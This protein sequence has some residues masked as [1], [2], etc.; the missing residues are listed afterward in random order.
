MISSMG[1]GDPEAGVEAMRPYLRAKAAAD[2][3][4]RESRLDWTIVR[5]GMLTDEPGSGRVAAATSLAR[6]GEIPRDDVA[7]VLLEVLGA[8]STVGVTFEVLAGESPVADAIRA[9]RRSA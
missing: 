5:P 2:A 9:L 7:L 1:A 3:A 8:P 4:L 6:R